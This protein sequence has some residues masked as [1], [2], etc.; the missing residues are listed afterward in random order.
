[1][2]RSAVGAA[3]TATRSA[4][5]REASCKPTAIAPVSTINE[6]RPSR[7]PERSNTNEYRERHNYSPVGEVF[8]RCALLR[9]LY[10]WRFTT[11]Y[12]DSQCPNYCSAQR[13]LVP[14]SDV[15]PKNQPRKNRIEGKR[16]HTPPNFPLK[17][18]KSTMGDYGQI[19]Q[20]IF[21]CIVLFCPGGTRTMAYQHLPFH[22]K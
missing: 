3:C 6:D 5:G 14:S 7:V 18:K 19:S 12:T 9:M 11:C 10:T 15:C 22:L 4:C 2:Q 17:S 16:I 8:K 1:M 13:Q 20:N 21:I